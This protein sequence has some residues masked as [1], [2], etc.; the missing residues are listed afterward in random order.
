MP[1]S[2]LD[3]RK[4]LLKQ[5]VSLVIRDEVEP[6][7][8]AGVNSLQYD[9]QLHRLYSAGRDSIIRIWNCKNMKDPYIQS[10]EHH[11][12]WVND[13]VLC[14]GG[15]N[16]ISASSDTTVKVWNAHKGFCMSTLRTHKDYVKALAYARDREQV[17][18]AGL[19]RAIFLWDVNTLT[20]LT[21][22][23]N[24]V[25]NSFHTFGITGFHTLGVLR[26]WHEQWVSTSAQ[27]KLRSIRDGVSRWPCSIRKSRREVV[28]GTTR[29]LVGHT[30]LT[31][32]FLLRGDPPPV[33]EFC[34]APLSVYHILVECRKY[35]P[36]RLALNFKASSLNGNKDSIY[37]LAMN[38]SGTAIV[39]GSTE[40]VLRV[41]DPRTCAKLMKL[42]GHADN[43][44]A[45]V[46]NRDG[47]Q[48]LSGSSD[49][50]I[51]L[52]SLG[53]QRCVST[54][55]VHDE[56][57][58]ALL[59]T[60]SF[61]HVISGGRDR[62]IFMTD[63]RFPE[64][65]VLICEES[66]PVLKMVL[67]PDQSSLWVATSESSI[68]NWGG[69]AV[70]HYHILNDK[71]HIIA[72]DSESNV[73]VYDV[74]KACK[75]ED[76]GAVDFD[77]EVKKR[78]KM[79]YVPNWFN[80]DLKT[81]GLCGKTNWNH[82]GS[83]I[84]V[85]CMLSP[86]TM[87]ENTFKAITSLSAGTVLP[88][89]AV[90]SLFGPSQGHNIDR[91]RKR[92]RSSNPILYEIQKGVRPQPHFM[93][94][95]FHPTDNPMLR[96]Y[97]IYR[98][99][100]PFFDRASEVNYGNLLLQALLEHWW[101]PLQGDEDTECPS[102]QLQ[103]AGHTRG[104]N[105]YFSV[106]GHT[107]VIFSEVGGRTLYRLL[108]RDAGGET[109]GVLLNETVPPWVVD[110]VVEKN[111]PKFIKIPFYL[112]PHASS[113]VKSLKK[114]RLIANDFIQVR[115]VAEHVYEKVLGAGSECGSVA[116]PSSPG[117]DRTDP[118]RQEVGSIAEDKVELL[119]NDQ[120]RR[121]IRGIKVS[122]YG[123]CWSGVGAFGG[124]SVVVEMVENG[125]AGGVLLGRRCPLQSLLSV[126]LA[127][128][129]GVNHPVW[130]PVRREHGCGAVQAVERVGGAAC[131]SVEERDKGRLNSTGLQ[132]GPTHC[133]VFHLEI[134][135]GP[136]PVLPA[137]EIGSELPGSVL[138]YDPQEEQCWWIR[139]LFSFVVILM[140]LIWSQSWN[141]SPLATFKGWHD[142]YSYNLQLLATGV[143]GSL[144]ILSFFKELGLTASS[145]LKIFLGLLSDMWGADDPNILVVSVVVAGLKVLAVST[146]MDGYGLVWILV[147]C[148][149]TVEMDSR[150]P[151]ASSSYIRKGIWL[152][153]ILMS[154]ASV[155]GASRCLLLSKI[156]KK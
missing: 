112:Q 83:M 87:A 91:R 126:G 36:I 148:V 26:T 140:W 30:F 57:V 33:C 129:A 117:T 128:A 45:L 10:M 102:D 54:I 13:I 44:K 43:V 132:H 67:T 111:L 135:R 71:R 17:A 122:D 88:N 19:D 9:P 72:K 85:L 141:C 8:R 61:S 25:T 80:V 42:K 74:L 18:S 31:H 107:P 136:D 65:R 12:D 20:A 77:E 109:E 131:T 95:H 22:S 99:D 123:R 153:T 1:Q 89:L 41:W 4:L 62:K 75:I 147:A 16:L 86:F 152:T 133:E 142:C 108:V 84:R 52:W 154:S 11:T 73:M 56:G 38:P 124:P 35:A 5:E 39:S 137:S 118:E 94:T 27:N 144:K 29:L 113:G 151:T 103:M 120:K 66:A 50:T 143:E 40:K 146:S 125:P 97:C 60:E 3:K 51:K 150:R 2:L 138:A 101:R 90:N 100:K 110:I 46:L 15:K 76:L 105:D 70:R 64:R 121:G 49:G 145:P 53:Q 68:K 139:K 134:N 63:I 34:D 156:R 149:K 155:I 37:S 55:R 115:K 32:G 82:P 7:H 92:E 47:T 127:G 48:C 28:I 98:T 24:T 93:E 119:C 59:T 114:D 69:P 79:V 6:R 106:P 116:G 130:S 81:G 104:G 21:A 78:F 96:G 58:W 14:C 23:N